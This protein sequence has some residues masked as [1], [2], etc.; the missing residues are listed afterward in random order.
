MPHKKNPT[1]LEK[2]KQLRETHKKLKSDIIK[3]DRYDQ[4]ILDAEPKLN[5]TLK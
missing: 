5:A 1:L 2:Q 4:I 3:S